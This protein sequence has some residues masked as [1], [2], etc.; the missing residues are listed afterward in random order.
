MKSD[1]FKEL[2]LSFQGVTEHPHFDRRAFKVDRIFTTLHEKS[3]TA[4]FKFSLEDQRLFSSLSPKYIYA[5]ANKWG[6]QGWTTIELDFADEA[7]VFAAIEAA[8]PGSIKEKKK[9]K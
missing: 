6:L 3:N 2:V 8:Y 4:N 1:R 5:I 9:L 7:V